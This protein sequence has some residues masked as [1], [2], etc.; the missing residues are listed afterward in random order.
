MSQPES[1]RL[2]GAALAT[3]VTEI[4]RRFD[5]RIVTANLP[6]YRASTVLFDTLEQAAAEGRAVG[7][8]VRHA[9]TYGTAG[10]PTTYALM[11]ALAEISGGGH[12]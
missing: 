8:G 3:A 12:A 2:T 4:G 6:V 9:S 10:T 11:D 5:D 1:S 7:E